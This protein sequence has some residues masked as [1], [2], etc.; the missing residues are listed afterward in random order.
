MMLLFFL[1]K[2]GL[3]IA[4]MIGHITYLSDG[5]M[6]EK[7]GRELRSGSFEKGIE[8]SLEFQVRKLS[9]SPR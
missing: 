7:F 8:S 4:R 5:L 6:G 2:K 9:S 1:G 3:A